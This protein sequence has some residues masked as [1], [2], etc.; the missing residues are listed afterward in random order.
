MGC[1]SSVE[2]VVPSAHGGGDTTGGLDDRGGRITPYPEHM[3]QYPGGGVFVPT[4]LQSPE[5]D[6]PHLP[7]RGRGEWQRDPYLHDRKRRGRRNGHRRPRRHPR[8]GGDGG[9]RA[10]AGEEGEEDGYYEDWSEDRDGHGDSDSSDSD[11]VGPVDP[12]DLHRSRRRRRHKRGRSRRSPRYGGRRRRGSASPLGSRGSHSG[13]SPHAAGEADGS[14]HGSHAPQQSGSPHYS[15]ATGSNPDNNDGNDENPGNNGDNASVSLSDGGGGDDVGSDST[16]L[17][18]SDVTAEEG[19]VVIIAED[20]AALLIGKPMKLLNDG[21]S[22]GRDLDRLENDAIQQTVMIIEEGIK[23]AEQQNA[24]VRS[25]ADNADSRRGGGAGPSNTA[26]AGAANSAAG[27]NANASNAGGSPAGSQHGDNADNDSNDYSNIHD[28]RYA[29]DPDDD[30]EI[31]SI[32]LARANDLLARLY[33][34]RRFER[35]SVPRSL[36]A[37]LRAL[38]Y[39]STR[40]DDVMLWASIHMGLA[41]AL[42]ARDHSIIAEVPKSATD[43]EREAAVAELDVGLSHENESRSIMRATRHARSALEIYDCTS[44]PQLFSDAWC[45]LGEACTRRADLPLDP[46]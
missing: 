42:L 24:R 2:I 29:G 20:V 33:G 9:G 26:P 28:S 4:G 17:G 12:R 39:L 23:K 38:D 14:Q 40:E 7:Q 25:R 45:A 32:T 5:L 15:N 27:D 31:P 3:Q 30:E 1:C 19:S 13:G 37:F 6:V 46:N 43:A 36:A 41:H 22:R 8:D 11:S 44:T 16:G 21:L 18:A 34:L 10:D 35:C